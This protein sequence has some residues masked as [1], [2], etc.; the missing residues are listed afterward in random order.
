ML[1][2]FGRLLVLGFTAGEIPSIKVNRLLLKNISVDGVAWGAAAWG[3]PNF[4]HEQWDAVL[5]HVAA[6]DLNPRIHANYPLAEASSA[7]RELDGRS[8]MGKV[9]LEV[10][11]E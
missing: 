6:G 9:V 10:A 5:G 2:P 3:H 7:I 8:V 1:A 11:G 4:I